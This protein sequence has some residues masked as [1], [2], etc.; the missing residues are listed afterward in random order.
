[1]QCLQNLR[2]K[3]QAPAP[4]VVSSRLRGSTLRAGSASEASDLDPTPGQQGEALDP[5]GVPLGQGSKWSAKRVPSI[6]TLALCSRG[7]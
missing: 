2:K 6:I 5:A 4:S 3:L 7:C 1:M